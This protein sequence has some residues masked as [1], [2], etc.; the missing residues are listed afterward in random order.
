M[1]KLSI[2]FLLLLLSVVG[3]AQETEEN[4]IAEEKQEVI[5]VKKAK[6]DVGRIP[7][8]VLKTLKNSYAKHFVTNAY[9]T[10]NKDVI[11]FI[12]LQKSRDRFT[13]AI[14]KDGHI[15]REIKGEAKTYIATL[16]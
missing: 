7:V 14:D 11:Y 5:V 3:F 16:N 13:I 1:K 6:V 8:S 9:K 2:F 10:R 4:V 12:E 15:I